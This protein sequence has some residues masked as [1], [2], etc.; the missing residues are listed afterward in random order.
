MKFTC[1]QQSLY[2]AI[3]NVSK[4]AAAKSTIP[5]LEGIKAR[6]LG[7]T[8]QLTGYDLEI[9]IKTE[10]SV[11]GEGGGEFVLNSRLF[12]DII[13]KMPC[14]TVCVEID[15]GFATKVSGGLA[16]YD[17][18]SLSAEEYPQLPEFDKEKSFSIPQGMLKD[19]INRTIFAVAQ[20]D[21]KPVLTGELFEIENG[22]FKLVAIDGYRLAI[23]NEALNSQENHSFI[24]PAKALREL[25]GLLKEENDAF[26]EIFTS[27][28]HIIFDVSGYSVISRLLEGEFHNYKGSIPQGCPTEVLVKTRDFIDSLER[29]SLLINEKMKSPVKCVFENGKLKISCSTAMGKLY[30]ELDADISGPA[31][32]IGFNCRYLLDALKAADT[33][34][35]KLCMNGPLSPMKIIPKEGESFIYLVL[36]VRLKVEA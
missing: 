25:A 4:A 9:G 36:P 1:S 30:E 23:R 15:N 11:N 2:E 5:A 3:S 21:I 14:E 27:K 8:L 28:K 19:M 10:I 7:N 16:E 32:E 31:V 17:L 12:T 29:C 6:L 26:C 24:V 34:L 20:T 35:A 13:R 18:I 33:D 22:S